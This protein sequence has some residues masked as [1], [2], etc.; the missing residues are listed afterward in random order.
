[1]RELLN[2]YINFMRKV[3][4]ILGVFI[5]AGVI[6]IGVVQR[7]HPI[8]LKYWRGEAT[9]LGSPIAAKVYIDGRLT[10]K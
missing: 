1:M 7:S 2:R 3:L 6:A 4:I 9:S 8:L 5:L 10:A